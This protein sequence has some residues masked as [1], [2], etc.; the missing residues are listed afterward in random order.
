M[1]N[2]KTLGINTIYY[3]ELIDPK[4]AK[5]ISEETGAE[6]LL[7]HGSH[8]V[9]KEEIER[10]ISYLDIMEENLEKL[11]QGLVYNE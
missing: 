6:M 5:V 8:N 11:K 1:E 4:V 3:E 10:G 7:L 9:S 2:M